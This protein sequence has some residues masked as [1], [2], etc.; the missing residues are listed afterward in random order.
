VFTVSATG[1][2]QPINP[3]T[4][5]LTVQFQTLSLTQAVTVLAPIALH[6]PTV[7]QSN[8]IVSGSG[9]QVTTA[10]LRAN[11]NGYNNVD[12]SAFVW[13]GIHRRASG[14]CGCDVARN[15]HRRWARELFFWLAAMGD[16]R[17]RTARRER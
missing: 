16:F 1:L 4:A 14:R 3:G 13:G 7:T 9:G 17:Q 10:K 12:V 8:L 2:V 5:S 11:F 6:P 15:S